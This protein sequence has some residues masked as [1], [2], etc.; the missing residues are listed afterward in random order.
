MPMGQ[1]ERGAKG[2]QPVQTA[3]QAQELWLYFLEWGNGKTEDDYEFYSALVPLS[4]L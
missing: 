3:A 4:A 1:T 2:I